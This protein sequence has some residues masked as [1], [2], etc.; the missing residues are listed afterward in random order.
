MTQNDISGTTPR[1]SRPARAWRLV[2]GLSGGLGV[3]AGALGAHAVPDPLL[4]RFVDT[5]STYQLIHAAVLLWLAGSPRSGVGS[6][7]RG[8][9][10]ARRLFLAG[11]VLFCGGLYLKAFGVWPPA[12]AAA[13]AGGTCFI[14][15]WLVLAA[16]ALF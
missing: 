10:L 13:P 1:L 15:A 2:A 6:P 7:R 16:D 12:V 11:T 14:L 3:I 8:I 5:A 4:A 9:I